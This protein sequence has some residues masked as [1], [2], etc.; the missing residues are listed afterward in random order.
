V[1]D[2]SGHPTVLIVSENKDF[3]DV[4]TRNFEQKGYLVLEAQDAAEALG[5]VTRHSRRIQLLLADDTD[6]SRVMA[7]KLKP[8]RPDMRVIHVRSNLELNSILMEVSKVLDPPAHGFADNESPR[9]K[10]RTTL[11]AEVD[12]PK[13]EK[14]RQK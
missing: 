12:K 4:L 5:S 9:A 11:A 13:Q 14:K 2:D 7:A 1:A 3:R 10:V 8:Y 6:D